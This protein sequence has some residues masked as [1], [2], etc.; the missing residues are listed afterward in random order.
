MARKPVSE[1]EKGRRKRFAMAVF[2]TCIA[3]AMIGG[4][5]HVMELGSMRMD[6]MRGKISYD[7]TEVEQHVRAA[8]E[9][10]RIQEAHEERSNERQAYLQAELDHLLPE[11]VWQLFSH[12]VHIPA[13][14]FR[15]GTNAIRSNNAD[16]PERLVRTGEYWIDTYP[17]SNAEYARFVFQENYRPPLSWLEG[18]IPTGDAEHPVTLVSWYNARDYCA[19]EGKRLPEEVEWEKAARGTD[20]RRWPWGNQMDVSRLNTYYKI[21]HSTSVREYEHGASPYGVMD[22]AGNV[23]EWVFDEYKPYAD[24]EGQELA[25]SP[26]ENQFSE[27]TGSESVERSVYRVMR[28]GSWKSD[29]FSTES[30]HRNYSLP[31]MA[32]DFYGFR[33]V[34]S[35]EPVGALK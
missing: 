13:G 29:P 1:K 26:R 10:I 25:F 18:K 32:S 23:S 20:A 9:D 22:M 35:K 12:M 3:A 21:G 6:E 2:L 16:R 8:G 30:Y 34:S 33:C 31:N 28:G 5:L 4:S 7:I 17:V 27:N 24:V 19:W 14:T 15:M 11:E